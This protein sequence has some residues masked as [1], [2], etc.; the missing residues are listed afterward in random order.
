M[1]ATVRQLIWLAVFCAWVLVSESGRAKAQTQCSF[2]EYERLTPLEGL[3]KIEPFRK[4]CWTAR[5][6]DVGV[7]V[8]F[9][10]RDGVYGCAQCGEDVLSSPMLFFSDAAQLIDFATDEQATSVFVVMISIEL[11]TSAQVMNTLANN[12][13]RIV[14]LIID[15]DQCVDG[16]SGSSVLPYPPVDM[17]S[18][19]QPFPNKQFSTT[20]DSA[21]VWNPPGNSISFDYFPFNV[22]F[23][24][25]T[26]ATFLRFQSL[27]FLGN[28]FTE[29]P[30]FPRQV[31]ESVGQM[32]S[33]DED[34]NTCLNKSTCIPIGQQSVYSSVG[35]MDPNLEIVSV[36]A[37][38]DST[39][40]SRE[41]FGYGASARIL[42]VGSVLA[43]AE[44]FFQYRIDPEG[45]ASRG[46]VRLPLFL[47]FTAEEWGF[48][49]SRFFLNDVANFQCEA[50]LNISQGIIGCRTPY[51]PSAAFQNLN[52][53]NWL[54]DIDVSQLG[55]S[56]GTFYLHS[57]NTSVNDIVLR[58]VKAAFGS[59]LL[60]DA[61]QAGG[62]FPPESAQSFVQVFGDA[63]SSLFIGDYDAQFKAPFFDSMFDNI[64]Q[65]T[66][67]DYAS[68]CDVAR[69]VTKSLIQ[70]TYLDADS[71]PIVN[72]SI[73]PE[74][75]RCLT[76][77]FTDCELARRFVEPEVF[78]LITDSS[79]PESNFPLLYQPLPVILNTEPHW[80]AKATFLLSYLGYYNAF[81]QTGVYCE[82][83]ADCR[84][85]SLEANNDFQNLQPQ[86]A[87]DVYCSN[88]QCVV[89]SAWFHPA[90]GV[91][92]ET[93]NDDYTLYK[94]N[95]SAPSSAATFSQSLYDSD[96]GICSFTQ[97]AYSYQ[98]AILVVGIMLW[99][100][101]AIP[102]LIHWWLERKRYQGA[103]LL[104][105]TAPKEPAR[106]TEP[107]APAP[108]VTRS[109]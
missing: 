54:G 65:L 4:R 36:S 2:D 62:N 11:Y 7:C 100:V 63:F 53:D 72:C 64:T 74:V 55:S 98:A 66:D 22:F 73:I 51:R 83:F 46:L 35:K 69:G 39:A 96:I 71:V 42:A 40:F 106:S 48:S 86:D 23:V 102:C 79:V 49:G 47:L 81:N 67:A 31:V 27:R 85:V 87:L 34:A 82:S 93:A 52:A 38:F 29:Q 56:N 58:N 17:F 78:A 90:L 32:W 16:G 1:R 33:C 61:V 77:N 84:D 104:P 37:Q 108:P 105:T 99:P 12:P 101:C 45:G 21:Y 28:T 25:D 50:P 109:N 92:L 70:L 3:D 91:G 95:E 59:T 44:S 88:Q 20:P 103:E 5:T 13:G 94:I 26:L 80:V 9:Q 6:D 75:V 24:N 76:G 68:A 43:V 60:Q 107:S 41:D 14:A 89:T 19:V 10:D 97:D 57:L 15:R 30:G 8:Q 18:P